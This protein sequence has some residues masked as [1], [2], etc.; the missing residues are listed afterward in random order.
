MAKMKTGAPSQKVTFA[1]A[2]AAFASV[3]VS[4]F[5]ETI[6]SMKLYQTELIAILTFLAGYLIPLQRTIKFRPDRTKSRPNPMVN[7]VIIL[8]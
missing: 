2:I 5:G 4:I 3:M 1:S 8:S 6:P 7:D